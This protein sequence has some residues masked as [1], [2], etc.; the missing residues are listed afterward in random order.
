M[1]LGYFDLARHAAWDG[2]ASH[3][4]S[5]RRLSAYGKRDFGT[6]RTT[7]MCKISSYYLSETYDLGTRGPARA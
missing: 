2:E 1:R 6:E 5:D 4:F 7:P 3:H